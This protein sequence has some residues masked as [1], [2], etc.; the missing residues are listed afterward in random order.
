ASPDG[1]EL[2]RMVKVGTNIKSKPMRASLMTLSPKTQKLEKTNVFIDLESP[3]EVEAGPGDILCTFGNKQV[4]LLTVNETSDR[5][6]SLL[7]THTYSQA[8]FDAVGEV[9]L[10]PRPLGLIAM[11]GQ[12]LAALRNVFGNRS[13]NDNDTIT[14]S[15]LQLPAFDGPGC[16]T[17]HPFGPSAY[18]SCVIQNFND[19]AVNVTVTIRIREGKSHRFV[20]AFTGKPTPIRTTK[21]GKHIVIGLLIPARGRIWI[22]RVD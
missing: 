21:S 10:C 3:I 16:V 9:L 15:Q 14:L 2:A 22:R 20:E 11:Q 17:F 13:T 8:D 5:S 7:N 6:I 18:G 12:A 4:A 1:D 19:E